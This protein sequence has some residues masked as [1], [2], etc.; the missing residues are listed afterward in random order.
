MDFGKKIGKYSETRRSDRKRKLMKLK[1]GES[2]L[3]WLSSYY[4]MQNY[5]PHQRQLK[6]LKKYHTK[7]WIL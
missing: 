2:L 1:R 6:D 4:K 7:N 3:E 5:L